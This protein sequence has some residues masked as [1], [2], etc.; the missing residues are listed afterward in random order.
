MTA[1]VRLL[2]AGSVVSAFGRGM[3]LP[4]MYVY[5]AQVRDFSPTVVGLALGWLGVAAMVLMPLGGRLVDRFGARHVML[6]L[7]VL[8]AVAVGSIAL[9]TEPWHAFVSLTLVAAGASGLAPGQ[10]VILNDETQDSQRH[11]VFAL[12][13][14]GANLGIGLGA[15]AASFIVDLDRTSTFV[16][17]F[18]VNGVTYL[19]PALMLLSLRHVGARKP[20]PEADPGV[21]VLSPWRTLA[22]HR[23]F[24]SVMLV[25]LIMTMF[26]FSQYEVGF[27]AFAVVVSGVS[28]FWLG[29]ALALNTALIVG[30]QLFVVRWSEGRSRTGLLAVA[31][32]VFAGA[33][34]VLGTSALGPSG[35]VVAIVGVITCACVFAVGEMLLAP[36]VPALVNAMAPDGIRGTYNAASMSVFNLAGIVAPAMA[37]PLIGYGASGAWLVLVIAGSSGAAVL[38]ARLATVVPS[39]QNGLASELPAAAPQSQDA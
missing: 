19:V 17:L 15:V 12:Q 23:E 21:A 28:P 3:T 25:V 36:T 4:Y 27:S 11:K 31:G 37:A 13:F 1:H 5:L 30:T 7:Y 2:L 38:A 26:A 10:A 16:T 29:I 24:R 20:A 22:D 32:A 39:G 14:A 18:L 35:G 8:E 9:A 33:W 6:P 34:V